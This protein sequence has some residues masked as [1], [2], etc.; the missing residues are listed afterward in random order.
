MARKVYASGQTY[1]LSRYVLGIYLLSPGFERSAIDPVVADLSWAEG[2]VAAGGGD[3]L[4]AA[5]HALTIESD[6]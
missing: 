5:E 1:P 4:P 3:E 6:P 2:T